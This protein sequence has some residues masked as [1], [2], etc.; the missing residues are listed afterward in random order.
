MD[1]NTRQWNRILHLEE[2]LG[3]KYGVD[4]KPIEGNKLDE[5]ENIKKFISMV[6]SL[7]MKWK[8]LVK[9]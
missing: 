1:E 6:E 2:I 5:I 3:V 8:S 4:G 7:D 9:E